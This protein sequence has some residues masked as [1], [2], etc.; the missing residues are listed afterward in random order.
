M[1]IIMFYAYIYT[2]I[3][4]TYV[5]V[6]VEVWTFWCIYKPIYVYKEH[7]LM[8]WAGLLRSIGYDE[9]VSIYPYLCSA[10]RVRI[11]PETYI[12]IFIYSLIY[13]SHSV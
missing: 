2:I 13:I 5:S 4:Y 1:Y 11:D 8:L 12:Y 3:I 7:A 6:C 10:L 9:E